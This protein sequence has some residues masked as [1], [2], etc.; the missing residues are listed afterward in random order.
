MRPVRRL[1]LVRRVRA[2]ERSTGPFLVSALTPSPAP[3]SR[4]EKRTL[5]I[6]LWRN[7]TVGH[8]S[9]PVPVIGDT[10]TIANP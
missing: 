8:R 3:I 4:S 7:S 10:L 2:G 5:I 1:T 6:F 9:P